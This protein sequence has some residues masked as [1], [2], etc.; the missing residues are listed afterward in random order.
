MTMV[1]T[2]RLGLLFDDVA[3]LRDGGRILWP[4]KS[5]ETLP[6]T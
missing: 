4:D 3:G 6:P 2:P 5:P 1:T